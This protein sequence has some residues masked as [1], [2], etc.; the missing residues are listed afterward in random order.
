VKN[1]KDADLFQFQTKKLKNLKA[2]KRDIQTQTNK[3]TN[4]QHDIQTDKQHLSPPLL[5][6]GR[7]S[8]SKLQSQTQ[9]NKPTT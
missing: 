7:P 5:L 1:G 8:S 4:Q 2:R 9:T 6:S 3:P